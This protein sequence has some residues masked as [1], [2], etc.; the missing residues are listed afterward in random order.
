MK[1]SSR[2][3][4]ARAA[5]VAG[6]ALLAGAAGAQERSS[7]VKKTS[8]AESMVATREAFL[9]T[10][11]GKA[12]VSSGSGTLPWDSGPVR[13]DGPAVRVSLSVSG[14]KSLALFTDT[15]E[16]VANCNIWGEPRLIGKDGKET[17]LTTLKPS[18]VKVGWGRLLVDKNWQDRPLRVGDKTFPYGIWVHSSSEVRFDLGGKYDRFEAWAGEDKDRATGIVRFRATG[19]E[20]PAAPAHWEAMTRDFPLESSW[21]QEDLGGGGAVLWF[22]N[23]PD[24]GLEQSF[25]GRI[26]GQTGPAGRSLQEELESLRKG[27]AAA[28]DRRWIDL[29]VRA[30]RAAGCARILKDVRDE[31]VRATLEKDLE[32]MVLAKAPA[33]APGWRELRQ[34]SVY[35]EEVDSQWQTLVH[36]LSKRA[37]SQKF[38]RETYRSESLVLPADRD[39]LDIVLRRAAALLAD[40]KRTAAAP[41][42]AAAEAQLVRLQKAGTDTPVSDAA[43]RRALFGEACAVRRQIA[44]SNPV[45]DFKDLLFIKRH[46]ALYDHMC[47]Q[48]YGMAVRPGGGLYV[49]SDAFGP[50]P[51]VR[52]VLADSVVQRGRLKGQ[53]LSGGPATPPPLHFD[54]VGNV[55]G[56]EAQGGSFLSPDLSY[57]GKTVLFA[58]V[59]CRGDPRHWHHTDATRGHWDA[60]RCYHVF[61]VNVDGSGL[62]QLTDGTWNDFDP[63]W[64]PNGRIAFISER[65]GGYL[66]CGRVC[67]TYTLYDMAADGSSINMLSPHETNEWHPSVSHEGRIIYTRWDYVDRHGC[68]AH[69]PWITT[70]DGRDSRALHGNF[71]PRSLRPDMELDCQSIPGSHKYLALAAPHHGQAYGSIIIIDPSIPDDDAMAPVRRVTPD[72]GF[73]ESQGGREVY[74]TPLP[75]SEDYY[76]SVYDAAMARGGSRRGALGDYGI[77]L[78]DAFG[79]KELIHRDPDISC[80][81]PIPVRPRRIPL[82][83]PP[84]VANPAAAVAPGARGEAV[85]AV[86]N[87]YEGYKGWPAG[88]RIEALRIYQVLPMPVPSGGPP[89]ET[90]LRVAEAGDSVVPARWVLGTVPVEKDGSAHFKVP[91]YRELFFQALDA[92]GQ[93]VQSMR[94]ATYLRDGEFLTCVGCHEPKSRTAQMPG[95]VPLALQRPPSVPR[96]DVDGSNPFSYPR[97]VQPVLDRKCA[98]CHAKDAPKLP[99]GKGPVQNRWYASYN[100]LVKYGFT[101]YG[102][103][104]RTTPGKFGAKASKL[105]ELLD[106]GHYGVKL[107]EE[108]HHRIALWLDSASMFYGVYEKEGGEIQLRGEIPKPTLE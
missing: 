15:L 29:Y 87:V 40:L 75:L 97:L 5:V 104:Y 63:C 67:P 54:G 26:V 62:E 92:S 45:L 35:A 1:D 42:L 8:W 20:S 73:P 102:D 64:L 83:S 85:L 53:K 6:L 99:L 95:V 60:G 30:R 71:A 68:T 38:A 55:H 22:A 11:E 41:K 48:Y 14:V 70:L 51:Q 108:E 81:S 10:P 80:L 4:I 19:G 3:R 72:V 79:N 89:H 12:V 78:V 23:R 101:R 82:A 36:D 33:E 21:L 27:N 59:E 50:A 90:G 28:G 17:R 9:Q 98:D 32:K 58:Y 77:Y 39:P 46:R 57:D 84:A 106:K 47:D 100:T 86:M 103:G 18:H 65:R 69:H 56:P 96:P 74:G 24:A 94:S 7:Y 2:R 25:V 76:L 93:A 107:T 52:D 43:A 91:A 61:K 37:D 105:L 13:G 34:K 16:G 88:T 66:R 31:A 49:L 44:F